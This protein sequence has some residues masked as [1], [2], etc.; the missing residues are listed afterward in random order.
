MWILNIKVAP[1]VR[2]YSVPC[3]VQIQWSLWSLILKSMHQKHYYHIILRHK[4]V[5]FDN[6]NKTIF[7]SSTRMPIHNGRKALTHTLKFKI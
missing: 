1:N 5:S 3:E 2:S 4:H 6:P 7:S